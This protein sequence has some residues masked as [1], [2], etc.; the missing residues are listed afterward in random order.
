MISKCWVTYS[1]IHLCLHLYLFQNVHSIIFL[2]G[3][4]SYYVFI[5]IFGLNLI[6]NLNNDI[7]T[8]LFGILSYPVSISI[9]L[10]VKIPKQLNSY[11]WGQVILC[12]H[13]NLHFFLNLITSLNSAIQAS[14]FSTHLIVFPFVS[15]LLFKPHDQL[16]S[17]PKVI[18]F[19]FMMGLTLSPSKICIFLF[20]SQPEWT[21]TYDI[22][23][24]LFDTL[25]HSFSVQI[26]NQLNSYQ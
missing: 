23:T 17:N 20:K 4:G 13:L 18:Q 10:F 16:C 12:L 5:S 15:P 25:S 21:M 1:S 2:L 6:T 11:L 3:V 7:P 19:L 24:S 8:S 26:P 14:L 22:S 9:S